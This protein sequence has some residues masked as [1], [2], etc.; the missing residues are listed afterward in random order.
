MLGK[1]AAKAT[2]VN[3]SAVVSISSRAVCARWAR[4]SA[5]GPAPSSATSWRLRCRSLK[6]SRRASPATPSRSTQPSRISRIARP[7]TSARAFHSGEPGEASGRQRLQARKPARWA[8][9]A[10]AR[11][12]TFARFGVIAGQLGRQ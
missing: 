11:K 2:S 3:G 6:P 8:A 5:S 7:T 4:A 12:R 9:A 10:L 1:P